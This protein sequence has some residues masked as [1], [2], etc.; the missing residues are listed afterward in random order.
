[1]FLF[2]DPKSRRS[3]MPVARSSSELFV[4]GRYSDLS[5]SI[6]PSQLFWAPGLRTTC[7]RYGY[8]LTPPT[9]DPHSHHLTQLAMKYVDVIHDEGVDPEEAAGL[10]DDVDAMLF[11]EDDNATVRDSDDCPTPRGNSG[12]LIPLIPIPLAQSSS[13]SFIQPAKATPPPPTPL[14]PYSVVDR[15]SLEESARRSREVE[16]TPRV[17]WPESRV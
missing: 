5:L 10:I 12:P 11:E 9:R 15:S 13:Y 14:V 2:A 6:L 3:W 8:L 4:H 17:E 7:I 16:L 1:M